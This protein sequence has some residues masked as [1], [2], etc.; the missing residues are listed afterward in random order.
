MK[1]YARMLALLLVVAL[2]AGC[3]PATP[4]QSTPAPVANTPA[5]PA[6]QPTPDAAPAWDGTVIELDLWYCNTG[7]TAAFIEAM[8]ADFNAGQEMYNVTPT[9]SGTYA[10]T[11]AKLVATSPENYPDVFAQDTEGA[12]S[13][14]AN[15]NMYV[16]LQSFIDAEGFKM[17]TFMGNLQSAY[18]NLAG[19][20][21]SLPLGNTAA[22]FWYNNDMLKASNIDA[23]NDLGS[24]AGILEAC[25]KL[26]AAGV[27]YPYYQA[28]SSSFISMALTAQGI[29]YVDNNNGKDG[30]PTKSLFSE[31]ACNA[32]TIE[33]FEFLQT[34][35]KEELMLPYGATSADARDMLANGEVAIYS[36]FISGYWGVNNAVADKFEFGFRML[37]TVSQGAEYVGA[38]AG[39]GCMFVANTGNELAQKGGWELLKHFMQTDNVTGFAM[40][41]GYMPT[42]YEGYETAEYQ[43][44]I[45]N[46]F[47]TVQYSIDAQMA[48][49]EDVYNAWLPMFTDFHALC[50]EYYGYACS[51]LDK[52]PTEITGMFA[53]AVDEC[54]TLY[55]LQNGLG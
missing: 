8:V 26:K 21:Q 19:Q 25:R 43:A 55:R 23:Q 9:Y 17:P 15:P 28:S 48:T 54:I 46:S 6:A 44:F 22:G 34:M 35:T 7:D 33:F 37:G 4:E 18:S 53:E 49:G 36:A 16:P 51:N 10:E 50:G 41:S 30:V 47:P 42:T 2:F 13:V 38:C 5:A 27:K 24:Y 39:G 45:E 12:Y 40:A 29:A 31:G 32:A 3:T 52:T 11:L 1:H 20:W 14:Y